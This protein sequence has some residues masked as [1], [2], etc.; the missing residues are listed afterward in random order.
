M[1]A[2]KIKKELFSIAE[3]G[4]KEVLARFFKTGKGQYGEG[5]LFIGVIVPQQRQLVKKYKQMPLDEIEKLLQDDYHECRLTGLFFLVE[6]FNKT[7]NEQE[8]ELI[9]KFYLK[10]L[11]AVNNWDLVDLTAPQIVGAYLL[12]RD[13]K[14]LYELAGS[15]NFWE[16]RVA[17]IS[18]FSFIK[19][20]DFID[21][22]RISDMLLTHPHDLIQ[23][24]VGW[25]LR[26]VGKRDYEAERKFLVERYKKMPRTMLRYAIEKF[27]E[28]VRIAFLKGEI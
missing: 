25:M 15:S 11:R 26:E 13:R 7:K 27:D 4:K 3:P 14:Y 21:T 24:A 9:F 1:N 20:G 28:E 19:K 17:I 12:N 18:T 2:E 23:K 16:Q 22:F 10:N 8:K 5:D 6:L